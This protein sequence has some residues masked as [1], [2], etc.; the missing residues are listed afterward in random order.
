MREGAPFGRSE[1]ASNPASGLRASPASEGSPSISEEGR[2]VASCGGGG[3]SHFCSNR[4]V[5]GNAWRRSWICVEK[6]I[7]EGLGKAGE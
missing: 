7:P 5:K 1:E 6:L 3:V 4:A 2:G